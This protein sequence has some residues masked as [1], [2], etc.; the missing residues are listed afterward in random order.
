MG[1]CLVSGC[2]SI[3]FRSRPSTFNGDPLAENTSSPRQ[4]ERFLRV[5]AW[6]EVA[7]VSGWPTSAAAVD[8]VTDLLRR[9][10][11]ETAGAFLVNFGCRLGAEG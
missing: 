7:F 2:F 3:C 1:S 8:E 10:F 11:R 9:L 4:T 6:E 5:G